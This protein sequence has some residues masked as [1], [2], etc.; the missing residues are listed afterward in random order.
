GQLEGDV[1]AGFEKQLVKN[2]ADNFLYL[3]QSY[4]KGNID[5]DQIIKHLNLSS[6]SF[7]VLKSRLYDKVKDHI[8]E[9]MDVKKDILNNLQQIHDVCY[10]QPREIAVAF[11][12]KLE[13]ELLK[14]DMH[15][16][17][18]VVYSALK[19]IHL[20]SER[21]F[22]YSQL[23]NKHIA[24]WLSLEK[25]EDVLGNF[26][27]ILAQYDFSKSTQFL[28]KLQFLR[29]EILNHLALNPSRQIELIKNIIEIELYIF[30]GDNVI[31]N[32]DIEKSLNDT[33]KKI[34]ELPDSSGQKQWEIALDYLFFEYYRKKNPAKALPY[35]QKVNSQLGNLLLYSNICLSPDFLISKMQFLLEGNELEELLKDPEMAILIDPDDTHSKVV[36]GIY[37][38][39][40]CYYTGKTK[41]AITL[42]NELVNLYS[43]K[44][45]FHINIEIKLTLSFYYIRL[46]DFDVAE[47]LLKSLYRKI[48]SEELSEYENVLDL[49]KLFT[50]EISSDSKDK[51]K[52]KTKDAFTLFMARN[53]GPRAVI[54]YLLPELKKIH[55]K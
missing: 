40:I 37:K 43:F 15:S 46:K 49:I 19:K 25:S 55:L 38:S 48:K 34:S 7:Y 23:F 14:F 54:Q 39:V 1:F 28:D 24:F 35:Y 30:C 27:Q 3:A 6:N 32:F 33:N 17:L 22:H 42:L 52:S 53:T 41:E 45:F 50:L 2:K 18:L 36:L 20:K 10:H 29:L 21:Y 8:S 13:D 51:N 5:D 16:E 11:L 12:E 9:D 4:R 44:D 26:N 47:N 31:K